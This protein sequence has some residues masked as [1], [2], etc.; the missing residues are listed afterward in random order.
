M[1]DKHKLTDK[2]KDKIFQ[3]KGDLFHIKHSLWTTMIAVDG[4]LLGAYSVVLSTGFS[5]F[6]ATP[7]FIITFIS[8][9]ILIWNIYKIRIDLEIE[10]GKRKAKG[11]NG[12]N[13]NTQTNESYKPKSRF[14]NKIKIFADKIY[15]RDSF[16]LVLTAFGFIMLFLTILHTC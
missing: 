5:N 10:V 1:T 6:L 16:P 3:R 11:K 12:Q 9:I 13:N 7:I 14:M 2:Q 8:L 15:W 4:I